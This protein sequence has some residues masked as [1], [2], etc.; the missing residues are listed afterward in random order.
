MYLRRQDLD[1][2][3][4]KSDQMTE[5]SKNTEDIRDMINMNGKS[6]LTPARSCRDVKLEDPSASDGM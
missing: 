3:N 4:V 6:S 2:N 5:I 1:A